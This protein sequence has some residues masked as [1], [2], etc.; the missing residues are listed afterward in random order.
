MIVCAHMCGGS[1]PAHGCGGSLCDIRIVP[2]ALM[3]AL[4]GAAAACARAAMP[5]TC[6]GACVMCG[7]CAVGI[8]MSSGALVSPAQG[9][10]VA[11]L[12]HRLGSAVRAARDFARM[13][14]NGVFEAQAQQCLSFSPGMTAATP[15]G[16]VLFVMY[17]RNLRP[18]QILFT[19]AWP[20]MRVNCCPTPGP[21]SIVY[22]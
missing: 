4:H 15:C 20:R 19:G 9:R 10:G 2:K 6:D 5:M 22:A 13:K 21:I 17:R 12:I 7:A 3:S 16:S 11:A 8:V 18:F 14:L 1:G